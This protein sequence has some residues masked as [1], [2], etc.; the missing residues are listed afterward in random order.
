[1]YLRMAIT[2]NPKFVWV[3]MET[4]ARSRQCLSGLARE[5]TLAPKTGE[6]MAHQT[7]KHRHYMS[8]SLNSLKGR[9]LDRR[10][11]WELF[12]GTL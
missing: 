7:D 8:Y 5:S 3:S 4:R 10:V 11:P 6:T 12:K 1:M 9:G 2:S